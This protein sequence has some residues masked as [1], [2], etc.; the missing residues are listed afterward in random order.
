[1]TDR[2]DRSPF[3]AKNIRFTQSKD[4]QTVFAIQ[5]A[6]GKGQELVLAS[7]AEDGPG[8]DLEIAEVSLLGAAADVPWSRDAEGLRIVAPAVVPDGLAVVYRI[9]VTN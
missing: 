3:T 6:A 5:L 8:G 7:F 2:A 1:M 4:G 9:G